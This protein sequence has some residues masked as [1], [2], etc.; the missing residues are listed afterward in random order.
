MPMP[1]SEPRKRCHETATQ[2][3]NR[4]AIRLTHS[5]AIR[6]VPIGLRTGHRRDGS[7]FEPDSR[8]L[9]QVG[10]PGLVRIAASSLAHVASLFGGSRSG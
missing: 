7:W 2:R 3:A 5:G 4:A 10:H 6:G 8:H 9:E 1:A